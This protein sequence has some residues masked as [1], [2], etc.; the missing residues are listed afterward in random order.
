[1]KSDES[2][3]YKKEMHQ[4]QNT[5]NPTPIKKDWF[6][7]AVEVDWSTNIV[8]VDWSIIDVQWTE[9]DTKAPKDHNVIPSSANKKETKSNT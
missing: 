8:E 3:T 5:T 4:D 6:A 1:M 7:N 2:D 9:L